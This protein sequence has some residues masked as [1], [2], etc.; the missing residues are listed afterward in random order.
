MMLAVFIPQ[1]T[2]FH[3]KRSIVEFVAVIL[4]FSSIGIWLH[5]VVRSILIKKK[6]IP[7]KKCKATFTFV[8]RYESANFDFLLPLYNHHI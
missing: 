7:A 8:I 4:N 1:G 5:A 3:L 2:F 6:L